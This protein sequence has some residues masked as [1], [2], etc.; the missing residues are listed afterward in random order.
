MKRRCQHCPGRVFEDKRPR[1]VGLLE[2]FITWDQRTRQLAMVIWRVLRTHPSIKQYKECTAEGRPRCRKAA[3]WLSFVDGVWWQEKLPW[4]WASW[5]QRK[6]QG[7]RI[8]ETRW[9]HAAVRGKVTIIA[10]PGSKAHGNQGTLMGG[11]CGPYLVHGAQNTSTGNTYYDQ[12][13]Y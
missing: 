6:G 4:N 2:W 1:K 13:C 8:T 11:V 10:V 5:C 12:K 7:S 9:R 3:Q